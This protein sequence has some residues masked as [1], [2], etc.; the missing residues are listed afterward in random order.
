MKTISLANHKG[1]AGKTTTVQNVG[2]LIAELGWRVLMIDMD[3]QAS[4]TMAVGTGDCSDRSIA[5]ALGGHSAGTL[6]L[7][8]IIINL[9]PDL[10]LAPADPELANAEM[11]L[12]Q[13]YGR[14]NVLKKVLT[15]VSDRYDIAII[16]CGPSLGLLTVNSLVAA[17]EVIIPCQPSIL[18]CAGFLCS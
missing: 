5:E 2:A 11:G 8:D 10:D 9:A 13:R 15:S 6:A 14:E 18:I 12:T 17:D 4:L 7:T 16:D 1:G 3:P